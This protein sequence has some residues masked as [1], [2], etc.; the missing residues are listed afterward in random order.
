M[1]TLNDLQYDSTVILNTIDMDRNEK[2]P[3]TAWLNE[4]FQEQ[5]LESLSSAESNI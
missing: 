2:Y 4:K 5:Y 1:T 3:T